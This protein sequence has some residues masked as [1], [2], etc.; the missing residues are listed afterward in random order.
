MVLGAL[1]SKRSNAFGSYGLSVG[2]GT[3][4]SDQYWIGK[5]IKEAKAYNKKHNPPSDG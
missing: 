3:F 4:Q 1:L 5:K 2:F